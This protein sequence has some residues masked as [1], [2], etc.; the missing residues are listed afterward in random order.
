MFP[1]QEPSHT[2][3]DARQFE[4][5]DPE[6]QDFPRRIRHA[7]DPAGHRLPGPYAVRMRHGFVEAHE[8]H[9]DLMSATPEQLLLQLNVDDERARTDGAR[10]ARFEFERNA[11][12]AHAGRG[13]EF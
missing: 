2:D 9:D 10:V 5:F 13:A 6:A 12:D 3:R 11:S 4:P 8:E 1:C 7:Y